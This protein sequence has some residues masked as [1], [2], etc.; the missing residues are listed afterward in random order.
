MTPV[1]SVSS[2]IVSQDKIT[3]VVQALL[4]TPTPENSQPWKIV[5]CDNILEIFHAS[6]RAK[7]ATF[8]DD[9]S[10]FGIGMLVE[11]LELACSQVELQA[12]TT[13]LLEDR[14]DETPWLRAILNSAQTIVDPLSSAIFLRHTDRRKYAGGT[15]NDPVFHEVQ[16]EAAANPGANIYFIDEYPDEYLHLLRNADQKVMEWNELRRDLMRWTRFTDREIATTRD[17]MSWRSFLRGP[18]NWVYYARSRVWWLVTRLDWFPEW[19]HTFETRFFDDSSELSPSSY[20]DGAGIGCITT[21][22]NQPD[23][24]VASGRLALRVWLL[25]NLR[26]YG[27]QPLTNLSST[28]YPLQQG[29]LNMPDHLTHLVANGYETLQQIFGFSNQELPIFCFRVGIASGKYPENAKSLRR[30]DHV[31]YKSTL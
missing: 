17:G 10:V 29:R 8:P 7:L 11:V 24:L 12:E 4:Q 2:T 18:E 9:L 15:L 5:V 28:I 3:H 26:G 31:S 25:F 13:L 27:L 14:S 19:L 20:D 22:S 23:D 21:A 16:R 6:D 1:I 30:T